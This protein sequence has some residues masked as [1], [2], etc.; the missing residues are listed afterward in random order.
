MKMWRRAP[1]PDMS[2][3]GELLP[4]EGVPIHLGIA[5]VGVR[6]GAQIV[7]LLLTLGA[8][9]ALLILLGSLDLTTAST[10]GAIAAMLF[11]FT[12]IPYYVLSE[13]LWNGQTLGK[14]LMK[15]KVVSN[16]G[17]SLTI[18]A[19]VVR[20]LMKEAEVFLPGTLLL[21]LSAGDP[22]YTLIAL[23]WI[24]GTLL[25]PLCN[26]RRRRLGDLIA[27]TYVIHLPQPV[28]LADVA[29]Y[30][31]PKTGKPEDFTFLSHHLDHYGAFEL[32]TLED[33]LRAQKTGLPYETSKTYSDTLAKVVDNIR[34]RIDY[35]DKV[36]PDQH[37]R[38]LQAFYNAQRA[39]LEQR[40]LFGERRSDKHFDAATD[41]SETDSTA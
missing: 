31:A 33:L 34:R 15:I 6:M 20:N 11:F 3:P 19:L 21:T 28:L 35:A 2:R 27:G 17:A 14:R 37:V 29:T 26:K 16:D 36:T 24:F 38:F 5:G 4:P 13:I 32:Q 12:R 9:I 22:I 40:Q 25:V 10:W 30:A 39:Y 7:D 41:A 8:A 18:H 1:K 23:A